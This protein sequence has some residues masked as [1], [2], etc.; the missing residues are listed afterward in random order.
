VIYGDTDSVYVS[1]GRLLKSFNFKPSKLAQENV[2]SLKKEY[3]ADKVELKD[4]NIIFTYSDK[5]GDAKKDKVIS[6]HTDHECIINLLNNKFESY[7]QKII[8][9]NM[10][11]FTVGSANCKVNKISFKRE[12]ICRSAIFVEKKKYAMWLL[13]DEGNVPADKLKVTGL[14]IVR[15]STPMIAKKVLK[16]MVFDILRKMDRSYTV[17]QIRKTREK[18]LAAKPHE[19]ARFAP[20]N[21]LSKYDEKYRMNNDQFKSTPNHVRGAMIYN[22]VLNERPDLQD[23]YDFI[24]NGDKIMYI[25]LKTGAGWEHD[26]FAFKGK[27]ISELNLNVDY[28][29]QFKV[30]ILNL[31]DKLFALME[32][33]MPRFDCHD[34]ASIFKKKLKTENS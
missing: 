1:C 15:S 29:Q 19:I 12:S 21:G 11:K 20:V 7:I 25:S 27:W 2:T 28:E 8:E 4:D 26:V 33:D 18:F 3:K 22:S 13:N 24:Y 16:D 32:W 31:M 34:F 5:S 14:D 17:D 9:D 30:A 10:V 23:K 6:H